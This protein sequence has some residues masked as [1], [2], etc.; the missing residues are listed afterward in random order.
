MKPL[1]VI[2]SKEIITDAACNSAQVDRIVRTPSRAIYNTPRVNVEVFSPIRGSNSNFAK[3]SR[4]IDPLNTSVDVSAAQERNCNCFCIEKMG[5]KSLPGEI[6]TDL[7]PSRRVN[8]ASSVLSESTKFI[9]FGLFPSTQRV[10][11][12]PSS[13]PLPEKEYWGR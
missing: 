4:N 13:P 11:Q 9:D 1:H 7:D 3:W 10:N 8:L 12:T 6:I 5:A 2:S